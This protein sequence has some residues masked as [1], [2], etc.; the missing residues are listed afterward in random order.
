VNPTNSGTE[1]TRAKRTSLTHL[2]HCWAHCWAL[3]WAHCWAD[4]RLILGSLSA[5]PRMS[6]ST[7]ANVFLKSMCA[8]RSGSGVTPSTIV[9]ARAFC[10]ACAIGHTLDQS[11][12]RESGLHLLLVQPLHKKFNRQQSLLA[13][14][15]V[16][17]V[18]FQMTS[19]LK[20]CVDL[21]FDHSV[22]D[23]QSQE[24]AP[25]EF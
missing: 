3:C 6:P 22:C 14:C 15:N 8:A 5:Q 7:H 13:C 16:C 4:S 23:A 1:S 10:G 9:L 24:A 20:N 2:A 21:K 11:L 19:V 12:L 17:F 18:T 25:T